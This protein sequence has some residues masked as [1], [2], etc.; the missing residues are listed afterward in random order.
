ME[1]RFARRTLTIPAATLAASASIACAGRMPIVQ[2]TTTAGLDEH[3]AV[4]FA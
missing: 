3:L 2:R 1:S 4:A